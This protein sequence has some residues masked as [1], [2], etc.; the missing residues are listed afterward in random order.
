M[1][2][3][4]DPKILQ[5]AQNLEWLRK[6]SLRL[7]EL[8]ILQ[9]LTLLGPDRIFEFLCRDKKIKSFLPYAATDLIQRHILRTSSFFEMGL[10]ERFRQHV[11]R[12]ATII[13][14]G[15][16]IGNHSVYFAR[17]C[18]ARQIYAF[19][20]MRETFKILSRNAEINAMD[21]IQCHNFALGARLGRADLRQ[22]SAANI[23]AT[24]LESD[25]EGFYEVRP[26]DSLQFTELN[27]IKMD[28]EG[29]QISVLVGARETLARHKPLIWIELLPQEAEESH[30]RLL[31][32][33]YDR[34]ETLSNTDFIYRARGT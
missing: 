4:S 25:E 30:E 8:S 1:D 14:A 12:G 32:L 20:P 18:G 19:E 3:Q 5:E 24:R 33:G 13:D 21:R 26:L 9:R 22:Y 29:A 17:V 11:P 10:L 31:S 15:A 6:I 34:M 2:T 28:V 7:D 16:N 27:L 23:G